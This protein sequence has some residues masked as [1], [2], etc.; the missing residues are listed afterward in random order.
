VAREL[1]WGIGACGCVVALAAVGLVRESGPQLLG[2]AEVYGH[3]WVQWWVSLAWPAIPRSTDLVS[4]ATAWPVIDPVVTWSTAGLARAVGPLVAWNTMVLLGVV[5]AFWGGWALAGRVGGDR[6]TGAL[7]LS[8]GPIFAGS[9]ASGLSE[10]AALGLVAVALV[11]VGR[12]GWR[13]ALSAGVLLG[14]LPWVGLYLALCGA[15]GAMLL[16]LGRL[17][18]RWREVVLAGGVAVAVASPAVAL[19]GGRLQPHR[20]APAERPE[21]HWRVNPHHGADLL[22]FL[23]PGPARVDALVRVH[24]AYLGFLV[25]ALAAAAGR[26]GRLWWAVLAVALVLAP[27]EVF[28]WGGVSTGVANPVVAWAG[29]LPMVGAVHHWGRLVLLAQIALAALASLGVAGL[30]EQGWRAVRWAPLLIAIEYAMLSPAPWPLPVADAAVPAIHRSLDSL[31]PGAVL[32][33]PSAG[34]GVQ[35]QRAFYRQRGHG[36]PLVAHPNRPGYGVAEAVPLVRWFASLSGERRDPPAPRVRS[37]LDELGR[38]GVGV[39]LVESPW[40]LEVE[41]LLGPPDVR[42]PGGAAWGVD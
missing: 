4:P 6:L 15:L 20:T 2:G 30:R 21:L 25:L 1:R 29:R 9:L 3:A 34:P 41:A 17:R 7:V 32:V 19:Q 35:V 42:A 39:V 13:R 26:R 40:E 28:R 33:V 8:L 10:D 18:R 37:S 16:S 23:S 14:L 31:P 22:S 12:R 27:G 11:Q 24:P 38:L 36:R 5:G